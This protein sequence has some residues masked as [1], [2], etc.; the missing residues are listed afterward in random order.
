MAAVLFYLVAAAV[1]VAALVRAARVRASDNT[2]AGRAY[3]VLL[4]ALAVTFTVMAPPSQAWVNQF[5]PDLFKLV[6]NCSTLIAAFSAQALMLYT[7]NPAPQAT[8]KLRPR[9]V[10]LLVVLA[11]LV[12]MFFWPHPVVLTGSFDPYLALDPT[13]A[14]YTLAYALYLGLAA[15]DITVGAWRFSRHTARYLQVGL[16]VIA[17]AGALSAAYAAAKIMIVI[18]RVTT[19]SREP[20]G[21]AA[22]VCHAAFGSP[23]CAVAV[24]LPA[25][26]VLVLVVGVLLAS[27]ATRLD[28]LHRWIG[29]YR[30]YRRLEP[31]WR[32]L[33]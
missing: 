4:A 23:G 11:V 19:G 15:A 3:V 21:N 29:Q 18:E 26:T 17:L 7:S 24:G 20:T 25:V 16:R 31:L 10:G 6:G 2:Q 8:A 12:T 30:A 27:G 14:V 9:L 33:H 13:L 32:H 1:G 22:G 28:R 5:V